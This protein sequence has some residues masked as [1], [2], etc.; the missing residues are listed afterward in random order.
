MNEYQKK[1]LEQ[2][3]W[4]L[5]F[6]AAFQRNKIYNKEATDRKRK[7]FREELKGYI[8]NNILPLYKNSVSEE[9]HKAFLISIVDVSKY[10]SPI[11]INGQI[12]IGTAQKLLNLI[13]KYFWCLG[14]IKEPIHFPIDNIIQKHIPV[15]IRRKWTEICSLEEYM[16][17]IN[18][19]K[20]QL[21]K[22]ETLAKWELSNF[23]RR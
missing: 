13:L 17:V 3:M 18:S 5:S 23:D 20:A 11:L 14:R 19:A 15:K 9:Q 21:S 10:H 1:F 4:L 8:S 12:S 16:S 22:G 6:N 2:E 7:E